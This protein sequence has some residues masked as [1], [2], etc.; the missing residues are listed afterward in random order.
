MA[1]SPEELVRLAVYG[2][3]AAGTALAAALLWGWMLLCARRLALVSGPIALASTSTGLAPLTLLA[4]TALTAS[5]LLRALAARRA[6]YSNQYE[7]AITFAWGVLLSYLMYARRR[8][9]AATAAGALAVAL[10]LL[11]YASTL[12]STLVP[13]APALQNPLLLTLHV[14]CAVVAYGANAVGF[15]AGVLFLLRYVLT[16]W[17]GCSTSFL[18]RASVLDE[19]GYRSVMLGFPLL[20]AVLLFGSWWSAVAWGSYWSWDPKQSA[21]LATWLI[22]GAYLHVRVV[23]EWQGPGGALLL[24]LGFAATLLT[25]LGNLFFGGLHSYAGV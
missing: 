7:F 20:G 13:Q 2:H 12:P 8:G 4:F 16:R 14:G 19:L 15:V 11:L 21:T 25:Y 18:P 6:P 22:Y 9:G 24:V 17:T 23:R 10:G 5:V 1:V 3:F